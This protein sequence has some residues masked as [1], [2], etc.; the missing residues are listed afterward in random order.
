MTL[1]EMASL[2]GL[3]VRKD[4][5]W[6]LFKTSATKGIGLDEAMEGFTGT[7]KS[8]QSFNHICTSVMKNISHFFLEM[9]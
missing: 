6:Q 8:R 4:G 3:P 1:S 5:K 2:L 7:L 9:C